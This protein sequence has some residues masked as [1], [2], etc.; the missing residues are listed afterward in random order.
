MRAK[1]DC[2]SLV[3]DIDHNSPSI[4]KYMVP[5]NLA[6][7]RFTSLTMIYIYICQQNKYKYIG[8]KRYLQDECN[9]TF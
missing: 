3:Q 7:Q 6:R 5:L 2:F 1:S 4:L 8:N 9:D